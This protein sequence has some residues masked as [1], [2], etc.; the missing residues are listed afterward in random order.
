VGQIS[1]PMLNP[2]GKHLKNGFN[3]HCKFL[4][5]IN[6]GRRVAKAKFPKNYVLGIEKFKSS[7]KKENAK[8]KS[9]GDILEREADPI[10]F[11][12]YRFMCESAVNSGN[13]FW[14]LFSILQWSC[15]ARCQ[16]IDDLTFRNLSLGSDSII[17][18]FDATK[19][20]KTG[21]KCSPENCYANVYMS[22]ENSAW[23][24]ENKSFIFINPGAKQ[25]STASRCTDFIQ[26]WVKQH[27]EVIVS[28]M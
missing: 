4:E 22:L 10:P 12:L 3:V 27:Y 24:K 1:G 26:S 25:G 11:D 18:K 16:N 20:D 17:V 9:D 8:N 14:W 7:L 6:F 5:A 23:S 28:F 21:E 15:L 13:A 2:E 19:M